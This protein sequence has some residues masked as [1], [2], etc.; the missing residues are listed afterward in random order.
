MIRRRGMLQVKA[1]TKG[2]GRR[3]PSEI[4]KI[5]ARTRGM[6]GRD[7]EKVAFGVAMQ[8]DPN[9]KSLL[10]KSRIVIPAKAGIQS[11]ECI[12]DTGFRRCD[13]I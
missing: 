4:P 5:R 2:G 7:I 11:F 1:Q 9:Q 8:P 12:L 13:G 3:D 10:Q 6:Q